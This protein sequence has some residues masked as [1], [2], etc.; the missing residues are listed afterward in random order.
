MIDGEVKSAKH[1]ANLAVSRSARP[2]LAVVAGLGFFQILAWG[3]SYYLPAVLAA[4]ISVTTGWPLPLVI[5]CFS[6]ALCVS[7]LSAWKVA[8]V[9][10]KAGG[11]P[12]LA[13]GC[14]VLAAGLCLLG[15]TSNL[16]IFIAAWIVIGVGMSA[17]LYD[18]AFSTL[19]R[20]YGAEGRRAITT[21][22]LFGGFASTLCWPLSAFL[23]ETLGWQGAC[24]TYAALH[25]AVS[26]PLI[27]IFI[28]KES[29]RRANIDETRPSAS[30]G[31]P[32]RQ[33]RFAFSLLAIMLVAAGVI[34]SLIAVHLLTLLQEKGLALALAVSLGALMGP[35]QVT[36]RV[37]EMAFGRFYH[38]LWTLLAATLLMAAGLISLFLDFAIVA[39]IAL[40]GAGNGIWSIA[41]GTV[42]L[43]LFGQSRYVL[44]MGKLAVPSLIAQAAAPFIGAMTL[45]YGGVQWTSGLLASLAVLNIAITAVL[46]RMHRAQLRGS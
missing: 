25:I 19:G 34:T 30:P 14:I 1:A 8:R 2:P 31:A 37:V 39:A 38:P 41:R 23:V 45:E 24:F 36:A 9:I 10:D 4:P 29:V 40:Y 20:L 18:A 33:D 21:L 12:V 44:A 6:L 46:L 28:P 13:I 35:S 16:W 26:L 43:V 32:D 42:P 22:T 3:S 7:G 17:S 5:G 11:R 27:L 15:L